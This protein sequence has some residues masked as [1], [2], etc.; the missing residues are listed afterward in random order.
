M[1]KA[2]S[3]F[4]SCICIFLLAMTCSV[5]VADAQN[6]IV[7]NQTKKKE[8]KV[9]TKEELRRILT[10][11]QY[12]VT[13]NAG[14][15]RSFQNEYWDNKKDGQYNCRCCGYPLFSSKSKYKSG[16][17]WPSFYNPLNKNSVGFT[18]DTKLTYTRVE[19]HCKNCKAHLGHVFDDGPKPTGKRYCMNSASM[20]FVDE[21]KMSSSQ[22]QR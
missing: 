22:K 19:V 20:V 18:K 8:Y 4:A 16:T 12:D 11:I 15:E 17:G 2:V 7:I 5:S 13:Q 1:T 3:K 10:P 6:S 21:K 14:T 9:K